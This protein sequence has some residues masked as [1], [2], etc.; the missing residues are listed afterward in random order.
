[1]EGRG[2]EGRAKVAL[3]GPELEENLS[4]RYLASS[5]A[6]AGHTTT[7]IPF[8]RE[9]DLPRVIR[10]VVCP[11]D[12]GATADFV[13]LSLAFQWRARDFLG[14]AIA[15][16]EAGYR[17]HVT[18]GG[19]FATF[20][21][22]DILR[23]FPEIDTICRQESEETLVRLVNAVARGQSVSELPGLAYRTSEGNIALTPEATLPDLVTLPRPDRRGKP[24]SCLGHRFAPLVS[25]RGCY[26]NCTF[27]C[28][29]AWNEQ[30]LPGKRYR[31]RDVEDVADEM[32]ELQKERSVDIFVFHD[33]NFFVPGHQKNADRFN[34]L[35]DALEKR[36][37]GP[38]ATV[39]KARPTDVDPEVFGILRHRLRC[40]RTY[41]G[42]E[43]DA[44]QGLRTL[45]RWAKPT[46]NHAAIEIVRSLGLFTSFNMLIFDPDTTLE[47]LSQNLDFMRFASDHIFNFTRV[48]LYA[49]T[50]LLARMLAEGRC[51]GDYLMWDY[52]LSSPEV[53]RVYEL[54]MRCFHKRNFGDLATSTLLMATR[55]DV[56]VAHHFHPEQFDGAWL[57]ESKELTRV[58]GL[59]TVT[60]LA[61]VMAHVTS[62][63]QDD[64]A[65]VA[66]LDASMRKVERDVTDRTLAL[67]RKVERTL[68]RGRS[69]SSIGDR[70]ATPLQ[71][72]RE[73]A[74]P[75]TST[76]A[77]GSYQAEVLIP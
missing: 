46:Q 56:E 67:G 28:I 2:T 68:G 76:A 3:V 16:R 29:A 66:D 72:G 20:A 32:V 33:D 18:T 48:E 57:T 77:R 73:S 47:S 5:L 25:S 4:L 15:L 60:G 75:T 51:R 62:G 52:D 19:H 31:L 30:S 36:G 71:R 34:A 70:V 40:I 23:D 10:D 65:L 43:T 12:G 69:L 8:N 6:R 27:C 21:S 44:D 58:L 50:P 22:K 39:V 1:M 74:R 49:G 38:F 53:Q 37:I 42:I 14:L 24:A 61:R 45:R 17:G 63:A 35:A 13:G 26:A 59:D 7:I 11:R 64:D 55:F 54:S 41:V 9:R